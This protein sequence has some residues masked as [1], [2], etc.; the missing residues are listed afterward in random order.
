MHRPLSKL[1]LGLVLA[2]AV[3]AA[4]CGPRLP[5]TP[6]RFGEVTSAIVIVNPVINAGSTT[7]I[8]TGTAR[9]GVPLHAANLPAVV[10]QDGLAL[11]Q[12]L[13]TG[14]VPITF[15][16]GSVNVSVVLERE[17]YDVVVAY[18][19]SGVEHILPPVRY[20]LGA[21]ITIVPA[22]ADIAALAS[23][24]A[25]LLLEAGHFP[26]PIELRSTNVLVFGAWDPEQG[27][28]S[29]IDGDVTVLGGSNRLRGVNIAGRLQSSANGLSV[30][31]SD[32]AAATIT[33]NGVSL[34]RNR[35]IAGSASVPSS[36]AVLVDN[37]GIP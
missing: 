15:D 19:A 23:D 25:I 31:F 9:N 24:D 2:A 11:V 3:G 34:L 32:I 27:P 33:G 30:A 7:S 1:T 8:T 28:L 20:P 17:L 36:N 4:G 14:V 12:D 26:G 10:T 22:G 13:P 18:T 37:T 29:T 6:G 5:E 16:T 21:S 35:F